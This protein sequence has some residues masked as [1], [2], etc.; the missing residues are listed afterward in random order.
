MIVV[1]VSG[2]S[3]FCILFFV[4]TCIKLD[5][6]WIANEKT[7]HPILRRYLSLPSR[8]EQRHLLVLVSGKQNDENSCYLKMISFAVRVANCQNVPDPPRKY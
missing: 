3:V 6:K 1:F 4:I 8:V 7:H 5:Y 2:D